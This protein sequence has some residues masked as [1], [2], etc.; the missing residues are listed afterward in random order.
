MQTKYITLYNPAAL[1]IETGDALQLHVTDDGPLLV[2]PYWTVENVHRL[3]LGEALG[4]NQAF[5]IPGVREHCLAHGCPEAVWREVAQDFLA[6]PR[7]TPAGE[8]VTSIENWEQAVRTF[9]IIGYEREGH[10]DASAETRESLLA[11]GCTPAAYDSGWAA[12][13]A[14]VQD[15]EERLAVLRQEH[16]VNV[17]EIPADALTRM[18][19][20][21]RER[22]EPN[23]GV[24]DC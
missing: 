23:A 8:G 6:K 18:V 24:S 3:L 21:W 20:Q 22:N 14:Y 10:I 12:A 13:R 17:V 11:T 15:S 2:T 19:K 5:V 7:F 9:L 16:D 1:P 4:N